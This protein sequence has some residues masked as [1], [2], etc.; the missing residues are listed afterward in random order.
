MQRILDHEPF[1][2]SL[3]KGDKCSTFRNRRSSMSL[4]EKSLITF[5]GI[6]CVHHCLSYI[7]HIGIV[8]RSQEAF[9]NHKCFCQLLSKEADRLITRLILNLTLAAKTNKRKKADEIYR[10]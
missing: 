8:D 1:S 5:S 7:F 6:L 9:F 10:G 2:C 4:R 3:K